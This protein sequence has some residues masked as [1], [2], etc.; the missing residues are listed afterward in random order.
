MSDL[1][2][3]QAAPPPNEPIS[4][5][6]ARAIAEAADGFPEYEGTI[7][8]V[9]PYKMEALVG[10]GGFHISEPYRSWE[11]VP[12]YVKQQVCEKKAGFFGPFDVHP[13]HAKGRRISLVDLHVEKSGDVYR[14]DTHRVDALF[15]SPQALEKFALPYYERIYGP[16]FAQ[17]VMR[18]FLEA[19][20]QFIAHF[21]WSE[22]TG[23]GLLGQAPWFLAPHPSG[24]RLVSLQGAAGM[25]LP[26]ASGP[27]DS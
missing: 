3:C 2:D 8:L 7:Y 4:V 20:V 27:G 23:G 12:D 14:L 25:H 13:I 11:E 10:R 17:E 6:L 15:L 9:A 26:R 24:G 1:N 18:Q 19:H 21:P 5:A 22:Y 16:A